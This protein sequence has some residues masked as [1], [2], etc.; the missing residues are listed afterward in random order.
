MDVKSGQSRDG[1]Y[2]FWECEWFV[3]YPSMPNLKKVDELR[4]GGEVEFVMLALEWQ[5]KYLPLLWTQ[6]KV[7]N[8]IRK[9]AEGVAFRNS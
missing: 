8:N 1:L 9:E 4:C 7:K 5:T 2:L 6:S 3:F